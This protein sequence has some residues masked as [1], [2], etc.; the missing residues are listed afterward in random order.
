MLGAR[1]IKPCKHLSSHS[2]WED[3]SFVLCTGGYS[4]RGMLS[5]REHPTLYLGVK[6]DS[7][8]GLDPEE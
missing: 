2:L 7:E 3:D 8:E 6:K 4:S 1:D 5:V